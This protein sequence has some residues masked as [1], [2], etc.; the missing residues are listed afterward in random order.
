MTLDVRM[1]LQLF[2]SRRK[3][4]YDTVQITLLGSLTLLFVEADGKQRQLESSIDV[5]HCTFIP[6]F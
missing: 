1:A 3:R 4:L 5:H 2:M 6:T